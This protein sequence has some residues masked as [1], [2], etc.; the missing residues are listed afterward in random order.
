MGR[1]NKR[2]MEV[3]EVQSTV[4]S[5]K[6]RVLQALNDSNIYSTILDPMIA[7]Y[8]RDYEVYITLFNRWRDNGFSEYELHESDRGAKNRAKS[9]LSMQVATWGDKAERALERLGMSNKGIAQRVVVGGTTVDQNGK[10]VDEEAAPVDELAEHRQKWA[11]MRAKSEEGA[12][13]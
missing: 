2:Q 6:Q 8:L 11:K 1:K 13:D 10:A 7:D 5:E 3:E 9:V 4:E 12:A